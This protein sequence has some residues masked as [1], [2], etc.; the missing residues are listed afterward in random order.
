MLIIIYLLIFPISIASQVKSDLPLVMYSQ[1]WENIIDDDD[2]LIQYNTTEFKKGRYSILVW[3][4]TFYKSEDYKNK[5]L[6]TIFPV[7]ANNKPDN[8]ISK[9]LNYSLISYDINYI[10]NKYRIARII[11]FND[12]GTPIYSYD[13]DNKSYINIDLDSVFSVNGIK[14]VLTK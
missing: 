9:D 7:D 5:Y 13:N 4:R 6:N 11:N 14:S 12:N 3:C 10:D 8:Y 2:K 1:D